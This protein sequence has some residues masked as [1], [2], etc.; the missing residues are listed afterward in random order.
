M[1]NECTAKPV[2]E[3][4]VEVD[5][6]DVF[7]DLLLVEERLSEESYQRGL[8]VGAEQG[9]VDAYH[10]GYHRGAEIGAELGFYYGVLCAQENST[11]KGTE[12]TTPTKGYILLTELKKEIEEFPTFNDLEVDLLER[13]VKLRNKYKKLCVLLKIS[14]KYPKPN[15]LSF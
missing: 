9:N 15:E 10:F 4:T 3:G 8:Q 13:L 11:G 7:D 14:A 2:A 12:E 6:N 5:I 1:T